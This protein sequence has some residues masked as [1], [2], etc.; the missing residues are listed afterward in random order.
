VR[1]CPAV[2]VSSSV[3]STRKIVGQVLTIPLYCFMV[4]TTNG[5]GNDQFREMLSF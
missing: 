2:N 3:N 4:K 5:W 1:V